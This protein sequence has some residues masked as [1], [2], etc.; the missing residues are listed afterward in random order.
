MKSDVVEKCE[1]TDDGSTDLFSSGTF[2]TDCG[3][4]FTI[5]EG[6]PTENGFKYCC[7]CGSP[8][9]EVLNT[10]EDNEIGQ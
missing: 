9:E 2:I 4:Y 7:Y 1:W 5:I 10:G 8:I 6:T 3:Q